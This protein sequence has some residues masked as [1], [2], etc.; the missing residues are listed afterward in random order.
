MKFTNK[1]QVAY[2]FKTPQD[3]TISLG[4]KFGG[5][6]DDAKGVD[7]GIQG[8]NFVQGVNVEISAIDVRVGIG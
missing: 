3:S 2:K 8:I 1:S 6:D 4:R 5:V 7:I